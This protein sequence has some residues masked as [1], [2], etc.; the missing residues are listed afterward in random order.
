MALLNRISYVCL[1]D[2]MME[3]LVPIFKE[4]CKQMKQRES[5]ALFEAV[6]KRELLRVYEE[7]RRKDGK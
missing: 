3:V 5:Q 2:E 4:K 7:W 6:A 1:T